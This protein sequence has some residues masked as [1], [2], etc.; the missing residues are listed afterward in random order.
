MITHNLQFTD[1][2]LQTLARGLYALPYGEVA[3]LIANINKQLERKED[4]DS[5]AVEPTAVE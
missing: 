5:S 4:G 3:M 2:E 1:Q